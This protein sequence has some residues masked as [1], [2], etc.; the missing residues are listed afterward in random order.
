MPLVFDATMNSVFLSTGWF[1]V[2]SRT[3]KPP[4]KTT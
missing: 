3:P 2:V 1:V 4:S